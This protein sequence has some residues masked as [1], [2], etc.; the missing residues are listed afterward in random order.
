MSKIVVTSGTGFIGSHIAQAC[1][2]AGNEVVIIDNLNE[3]YS[4]TLKKRI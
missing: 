1:A 2:K 4:P 3:Y